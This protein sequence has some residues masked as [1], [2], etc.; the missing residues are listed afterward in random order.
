M[1]FHC[2]CRYWAAS[3]TEL[4]KHAHREHGARRFYLSGDDVVELIEVKG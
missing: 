2:P 4:L 1:T 3:L